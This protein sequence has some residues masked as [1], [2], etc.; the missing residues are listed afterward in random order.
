MKE[1]ILSTPISAMSEV[2]SFP[3]IIAS[4]APNFDSLSLSLQHVLYGVFSVKQP[5]G[6]AGLSAS[7]SA[8]ISIASLKIRNFI[9]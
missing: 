5:P 7:A 9:H 1:A 8:E 6:D 2:I 3:G 4:R